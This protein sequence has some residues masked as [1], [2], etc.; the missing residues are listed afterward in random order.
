[1]S[2]LRLTSLRRH[3]RATLSYS[4]A[5]EC[6]RGAFLA[7]ARDF[8]LLVAISHFNITDRRLL[9]VLSSAGFFGMLLAIFGTPMTARWR[10]KSLVRA[11]EFASRTAAILAAFA[12]TGPW[13]VVLMGVGIAANTLV[14]PFVSGIYGANFS[15]HVRGRAVGRLQAATV[16]T[17]AL[18]AVVLGSV[19]QPDAANFRP[20]L[21]TVSGLSLVCAWY[22]WRLPEARPNP[23]PI[24]R[25]SP[26]DL[27]HIILTD[28]AFLY[29]ELVWF[30][31]GI[32]NLWLIPLRVLYLKDIGF[33]GRQIM[34]TTTATM[35]AMMVL[36]VGVWGRLVYRM[37][38]AVF[39]I[40]T[41]LLFMAGIYVFF[42]STTPLTVGFGCALWAVGL[43]GGGLCWRLVATFFTTQ[44]RFPSYMCVHTVFCG[45]RGI[46]GP[47]LSLRIHEA[48]GVQTVVWLSIIGMLLTIVALIPL[49][50]VMKRRGAAI[51]AAG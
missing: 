30:V 22:T 47:Y 6:G 50:P 25:G 14:L 44:D 28:R 40:A 11:M 35:Y 49:V 10:K 7:L 3:E 41:I 48:Y 24:E 13:F 4:Y 9:W 39:R 8:A 36:S 37:N 21:V 19:M 46:I 2:L 32:C 45:I 38:F 43:A 34:F 18:I 27:L 31:M 29:I 33:S 12:L 17:T 26:R 1:M 5:G 51:V 15:T 42:H 20:L 16:G 23:S